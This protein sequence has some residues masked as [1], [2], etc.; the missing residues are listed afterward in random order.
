MGSTK[1]SNLAG[2]AGVPGT[3]P[4]ELAVAEALDGEVAGGVLAD[5]QEAALINGAIVAVTPEAYGATGTGVT[6]DTPAIQAMF[7]AAQAAGVLRLIKFRE[8]ATYFLDSEV[9]VCSDYVSVDARGARFIGPVDGTPEGGLVTLV[10]RANPTR[11][12]KWINWI[13]GVFQTKHVLDNGLSMCAAE[14]V[15]ISGAQVDMKTFGGQRGFAIQV[16]DVITGTPRYI[17]IVDCETFGGVDGFNVDAYRGADISFRNIRAID[18]E[19]GFRASSGDAARTI[20]RLTVDG[21]DIVNCTKGMTWA[22]C[23]DATIANGQITGVTTGRGIDAQY[24]TGRIHD[25]QVLGPA[26]TNHAITLTQATGMSLADIVIEGTFTVGLWAGVNDLTCR[27]VSIKGAT[28]GLHTTGINQRNVY[29]GFTFEGVTTEVNVQRT[30]D[31][32][33]NFSRRVAGKVVP[34][35]SPSVVNMPIFGF[36]ANT[37]WATPL[38][39]ALVSSGAVDAQ[40]QYR[41][42]ADAGTYTIRLVH[43]RDADRG[44]YSF[45]VDGVAVGTIDGYSAVAGP[46]IGAVTGVTFNGSGEHLIIVRMSTKHASATSFVGSIQGLTLIKT[47]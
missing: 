14:H 47:A 13:G 10:D 5:K 3:I 30:D 1:L 7:D 42:I 36:V 39:G 43:N 35:L 34:L 25:V 32:Y 26:A 2:V 11:T 38:A 12:V 31:L 29:D 21:F 15:L 40:V 4:T 28:E 45:L 44:I 19:L 27:G 16:N 18:A 37:N 24:S 20:D 33:K 46:V 41:V 22:G 8:G 6:N 17:Q 9:E 23:R